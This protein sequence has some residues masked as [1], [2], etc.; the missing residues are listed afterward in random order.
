MNEEDLLCFNMSSAQD[1]LSDGHSCASAE[2]RTQPAAQPLPVFD[3]RTELVQWIAQ[4]SASHGVTRVLYDRP[5]AYMVCCPRISSCGAMILGMYSP[6]ARKYSIRRLNTLHACQDTAILQAAI[7]ELSKPRYSGMRTGRIAEQLLQRGFE[8][9][10]LEVFSIMRHSV[11]YPSLHPSEAENPRNRMSQRTGHHCT[12]PTSLQYAELHECL[13]CYAAELRQLNPSLF[14]LV[15]E[16][17]FFL[18]QPGHSRHLRRISE[19]KVFTRPTGFLVAGVLFGP[20]NEPIVESF[21][22]SDRDK[23]TAIE[24]FLRGHSLFRSAHG[25]AGTSAPSA[26]DFFLVDLDSTVIDI[27]KA[28]GVGFFIKTRSVCSYFEDIS[29]DDPLSFQYFHDCNYGHR[30]YLNL[31]PAFYLARSCPRPLF[32]LNNAPICDLPFITDTVLSLPFTDCLNALI[33]LIGEDIASRQAAVREGPEHRLPDSIIEFING[34]LA[35]TPI[36]SIDFKPEQPLPLPLSQPLPLPHGHDSPSPAP[37]ISQPPVSRADLLS[38]AL[39]QGCPCG[40]YQEFLVP[41]IHATKKLQLYG[42]NP[43]EFVSS[44]Y[45]LDNLLALD[46]LIPAINMK[47][48]LL[49]MPPIWSK[50]AK[51]EP[52]EEPFLDGLIEV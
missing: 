46:K 35:S 38:R 4:Q 52:R 15:S 47:P 11:Q 3:S 50:P 26:G 44:V 24:A 16:N 43:T 28:A 5:H 31:E 1:I 10:Y 37:S 42:L 22:L 29:E 2:P 41:C 51:K 20:S 19:L 8:F 21:L 33:W 34:A 13:L 45:L 7:H 12:A 40:K 30:E 27:L 23:K 17:G 9:G 39:V 36:N 6:A 49:E 32:N 18:K 48:R 25:L 14:V